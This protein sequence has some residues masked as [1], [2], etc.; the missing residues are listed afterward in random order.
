MI[1]IPEKVSN[2]LVIK[3]KTSYNL[4]ILLY[5]VRKLGRKLMATMT[6]NS[7]RDKAL[8]LVLNQIERNF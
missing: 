8:G 1:T 7:D 4:C 5:Y 6:N 2:F 3:I